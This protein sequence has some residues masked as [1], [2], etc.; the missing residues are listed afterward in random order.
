M[1]DTSRDQ[2]ETGIWREH[3]VNKPLKKYSVPDN[4]ELG[5]C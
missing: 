2:E 4:C 3:G 5:C 1:R